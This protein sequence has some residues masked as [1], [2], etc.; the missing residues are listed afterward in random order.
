MTTNISFHTDLFAIVWLLT[1]YILL[2]TLLVIFMSWAQAF[3]GR[4]MNKSETNQKEISAHAFS[5]IQIKFMNI[6]IV[7]FSLLFCSN[8]YQLHLDFHQDLFLFFGVN[9]VQTSDSEINTE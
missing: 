1:S 9:K 4:Q 3:L 7:F 2:T 5:R 6:S 8:D